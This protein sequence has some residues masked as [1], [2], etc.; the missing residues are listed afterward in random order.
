MPITTR[1]VPEAARNHR[2]SNATA[3]KW[4]KNNAVAWLTIDGTTLLIEDWGEN[5]PPRENRP[6]S[7]NERLLEAAL[8]PK[9]PRRPMPRG[10]HA[11][12]PRKVAENSPK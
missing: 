2:V 3:W 9:P 12:R 8:G 4:V 6:P 10:R 11:G 5:P 1:R 7:L